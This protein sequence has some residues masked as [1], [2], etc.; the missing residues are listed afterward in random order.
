VLTA[1]IDES[2]YGDKDIIVLAGF[3]GNDQEWSLC[4]DEWKAGLGT[5]KSLHMRSLR[6]KNT[7][8]IKP[9]LER[10]GP[11]PHNCGLTPAWAR[12]RV[13]DYADLI[14]D[15]TVSRKIQCGY[16]L[17]A[18]YLGLVLLGWVQMMDQRIKIIF[19]HNDHF[20]GILPVILEGY[21][22]L[23]PFVTTLGMRCLSG[24]ELVS[25]NSS[26]LTQPADYLAYARLQQLRDPD[27]VK[28]KLCSP[29]LEPQNGIYVDVERDAIR[30]LMASPSQ[31]SI[32]ALS[33]EIE[34]YLKVLRQKRGR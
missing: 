9:L 28:S 7:E 22:Q 5:R 25:K 29:I 16:M 32:R 17:A 13:S 12:L 14:D 21:G 20:A 18:Q 27:S 11:I 1:Y 2:G 3:L 31:A 30:K 34:P 4:S 33:R 24:V 8:R 10:L 15:S 26:C 23:F 19:E 6:W